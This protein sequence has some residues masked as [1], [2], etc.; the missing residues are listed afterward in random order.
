LKQ[1]TLNLV[2]KYSNIPNEYCE[3]WGKFR[4]QAFPKEY[5]FAS[6]FFTGQSMF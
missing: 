4:T 5:D 2:E 6:L 3:Q 1:N